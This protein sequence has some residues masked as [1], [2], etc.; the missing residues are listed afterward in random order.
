MANRVDFESLVSKLIAYT[1]LDRC[2]WKDNGNSSYR[3]VLSG[4]SVVFQAIFR[5]EIDDYDYKMDLY[6]LKERFATYNGDKL[7]NETYHSLLA[8]LYG[9]IQHY[10]NRIKEEKIGKL[11]DSIG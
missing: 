3:L 4:G 7:A 2:D 11:Y 1:D 6:D 10:M 5:L 8:K 9:S